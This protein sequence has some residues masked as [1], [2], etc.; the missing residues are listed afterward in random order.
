VDVH[1]DIETYSEVELSEVGAHVYAA[2]PS[3]RILLLSWSADDGSVSFVTGDVPVQ[4]HRAGG[5]TPIPASFVEL[6]ERRDTTFVA[7][8]AAFERTVLRRFFPDAPWLHPCRWRCT[9]VHAL[10]LG[11]PASLDELGEVL[12]LGGKVPGGAKL[13]RRFC[14]PALGGPWVQPEPSWQHVS[15]ARRLPQLK[16]SVPLVGTRL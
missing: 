9:M 15:V 4:T 16:V 8:N 1:I 7:H 12:G 13:I 5:V 6:I 11:L 2:H 14:T 3:T 10:A